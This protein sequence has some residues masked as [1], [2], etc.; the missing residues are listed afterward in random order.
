MRCAVSSH[1][2]QRTSFREGQ[3]RKGGERRESMYANDKA[4]EVTTGRI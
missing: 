3:R 1:M 4:N 2:V